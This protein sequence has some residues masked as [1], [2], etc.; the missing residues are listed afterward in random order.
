MSLRITPFWPLQQHVKNY[1]KQI[2][3]N[4]W[5]KIQKAQEKSKISFFFFPLISKIIERRLKTNTCKSNVITKMSTEHAR[6]IH[7]MFFF[8]MFTRK[9]SIRWHY[10]GFLC[11]A[12]SKGS[13]DWYSTISKYLGDFFKKQIKKILL[14]HHNF[15]P[16]SLLFNL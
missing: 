10:C 4:W 8:Q 7:T 11:H 5:N 13:I 14:L 12:T 9:R 6:N 1:D 2:H 15:N 16:I 3:M